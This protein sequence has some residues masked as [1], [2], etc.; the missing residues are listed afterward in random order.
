MTLMKSM[1]IMSVVATKM[2]TSGLKKIL[3]IL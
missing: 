3:G 2:A 1:M